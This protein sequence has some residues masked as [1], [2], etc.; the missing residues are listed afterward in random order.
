MSR[1]IFRLLPIEP[2]FNHL[3]KHPARGDELG[4]FSSV[5]YRTRVK[6][7]AEAPAPEVRNIST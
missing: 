6:L 5:A 7:F 1:E 4:K 3:L 2:E